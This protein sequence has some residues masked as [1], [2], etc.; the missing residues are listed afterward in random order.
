M[1]PLL[2]LYAAAITLSLTGCAYGPYPV[3]STTTV[4]YGDE[5]AVLQGPVSDTKTISA[6]LCVIQ[7]TRA[8]SEWDVTVTSRYPHAASPQYDI[9]DSS[10]ASAKVLRFRPRESVTHAVV[11][12]HGGLVTFAYANTGW[13]SS[14]LRVTVVDENNNVVHQEI[15]K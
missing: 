14:E 7:A 12:V 15:L 5:T 3:A 11:P 9:V 2:P 1:K 8:G 4:R 13:G 10:G 6:K